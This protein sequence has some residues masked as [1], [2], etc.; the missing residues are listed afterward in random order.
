MMSRH[1]QCRESGRAIE[2][3]V[4]VSSLLI[5]AMSHS[6]D[7]RTNP[8]LGKFPRSENCGKHTGIPPRMAAPLPNSD[9][10]DT[11][12]LSTPSAVFH[13]VTWAPVSTTSQLAPQAWLSVAVG[14]SLR[15]SAT[16]IFPAS[17]ELAATAAIN[18]GAN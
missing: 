6:T 12:N 14:K 4:D 11:N 10:E 15:P 18:T 7:V 16:L 17:G 13:E 3:T 8:C 1:M 2:R 5:S 9:A